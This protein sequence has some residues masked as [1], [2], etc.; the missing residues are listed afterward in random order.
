MIKAADELERIG[1]PNEAIR[2][3]NAA[4]KF[5]GPDGLITKAAG[6]G[7]HA[8]ARSFDM[9]NPDHQLKINSLVSGDLNQFKKWNFDI[10]VKRY[11]DEYNLPKLKDIE[12]ITAY[13]IP[14][15]EYNGMTEEEY[16]KK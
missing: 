2:L 3:R 15:W 5:F 13:H 16:Y 10:P 1:R 4:N 7:E 14:V 12:I 6:E 11:F 8:L 9:L